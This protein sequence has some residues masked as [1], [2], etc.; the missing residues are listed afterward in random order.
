MFLEIFLSF[1]ESFVKIAVGNLEFNVNRI[2]AHNR[3]KHRRISASAVQQFPR[4]VNGFGNLA[5]NGRINL[6]IRQLTNL[7]LVLRYAVI[8][9]GVSLLPRGTVLDDVV[10]RNRALN[11]FV[12]FDRAFVRRSGRDFSRFG[13]YHFRVGFVDFNFVIEILNGKQQLTFVYD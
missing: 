12:G 2:H 1:S 10:F 8:E 4:G 13:G 9:I 5:F 11:L 3:A 7:I 6:G